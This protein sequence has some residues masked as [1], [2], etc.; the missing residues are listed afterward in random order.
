LASEMRGF[1]FSIV[2][3]IIFSTLL[4]S[5][6]TGLQ[7]TGS[8]AETVIP[9]DPSL[10]T[11]FSD[12]ANWTK[13]AY[14]GVIKTYQ[15]ELGARTYSTLWADLADDEFAIV[16]LVYW[17]I[18]W[19][20]QTDPCKFISPNG[21]ERGTTLSINEIEG[22]ADDGS[23]RYSMLFTTTGNDA[24]SFV[25]VWNTTLYSDPQDAMDNDVLYLLHGVGFSASATTDVGAL[26]VG[27][28][29]L[30]LPE[31][32]ALLNLFLA[33]PIWACIIYVIWFVVKEMIPFL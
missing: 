33:V 20:G 13:S 28:L 5:V 21:T 14:T 9:V 22:D 6:P 23:V 12:M 27:L 3:I 15:Y 29:F 1:V 32:P 31:V 8:T 24:G 2:F 25:V 18:L 26:L 4:A 16:A 30:Q 11:G 10:L 7:G 17:W 19:F